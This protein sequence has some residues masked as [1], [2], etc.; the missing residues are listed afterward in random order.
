MPPQDAQLQN[1]YSATFAWNRSPG[2]VKYRLQ[3]WQVDETNDLEYDITVDGLEY[4]L[5]IPDKVGPWM[6]RVIAVGG[7]GKLGPIS[8]NQN[9]FAVK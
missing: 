5:V 6:W 2:A 9:R 8:R 3:L 7:D 4:T 1:G